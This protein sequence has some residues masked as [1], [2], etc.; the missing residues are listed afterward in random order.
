MERAMRRILAMTAMAAAL[1]VSA[2]AFAQDDG[3]DMPKAEKG[4]AGDSA[5]RPDVDEDLINNNLATP[6]QDELRRGESESNE[7]D[8]AE[9]DGIRTNR[10]EDQPGTVG[11]RKVVP[12]GVVGGEETPP[13]NEDS[14]AE[15]PGG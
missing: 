8:T 12:G 14:K 2:P 5:T 7:G 6:E 11:N 1:M 4:N 13:G 9:E 15:S 10:V 3:V